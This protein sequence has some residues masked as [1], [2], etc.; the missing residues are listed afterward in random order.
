MKK[1]LSKTIMPCMYCLIAFAT[2]SLAQNTSNIQI[3]D[4]IAIP[5]FNTNLDSTQYHFKVFFKISDASNAAKAHILVGDTTNSGNV[6]TA[7]PVFTHTGAGN[8]SL[9]YNTQ[10]TKIV[11]YTATLFVDVP[12][13][14]LPLM[15]YLTL[16]VEDLTGK[17]TSKLYFKL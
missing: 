7:I 12:K 15:H 13:T 2:T 8:D 1:I 16:Y 11:N 14:E 3:I 5:E 10:I 17:Y 4:L 9:V 6:L